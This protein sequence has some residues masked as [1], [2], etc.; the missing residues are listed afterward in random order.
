MF[1]FFFLA[2]AAAGLTQQ[3]DRHLRFLSG[4]LFFTTAARMGERDTGVRRRRTVN[5]VVVRRGGGEGEKGG[6]Q[7]RG[8]EGIHFDPPPFV[9]WAQV[10]RVST[11]L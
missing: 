9:E 8:K 2:G 11:M 3:G 10:V 6:E 1:L 4:G 5:Y 7:D